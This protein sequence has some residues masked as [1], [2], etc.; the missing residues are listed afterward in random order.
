MQVIY[1]KKYLIFVVLDIPSIRRMSVSY[2]LKYAVLIIVDI[3]LVIGKRVSI[4]NK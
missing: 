2:Y 1:Y 4:T 3:L